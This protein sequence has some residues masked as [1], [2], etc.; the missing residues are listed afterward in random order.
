MASSKRQREVHERITTRAYHYGTDIT[1]LYGGIA[2]GCS[3]S[4]FVQPL[5]KTRV[6]RQ[7]GAEAACSKN[8][9]RLWLRSF[10]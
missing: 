9:V 5:R 10:R 7:A 6:K 8:P 2:Q 3:D 1:Q 4:G